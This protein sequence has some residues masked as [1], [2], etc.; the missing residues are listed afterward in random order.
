MI[1][2][3]RPVI[4]AWSLAMVGML[5]VVSCSSSEE[6]IPSSTTLLQPSSTDVES[7]TT[8]VD[9]DACRTDGATRGSGDDR[10]RCINGTWTP[11]PVSST[12]ASPRRNSP[13]IQ[14]FSIIS[15]L[16]NGDEDADEIRRTFAAFVEDL[17][18]ERADRVSGL[19]VNQSTLADYPV[20]GPYLVIEATSGWAGSQA[21]AE[22]TIELTFGLSQF[23]TEELLAASLDGEGMIN[24]ELIVDGTR[25]TITGT[26]MFDVQ[27]RVRSAVDVL[28]ASIR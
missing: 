14:N 6:A 2:S 18:L 12:T 3:I 5:V 20:A 23:W 1:H 7:T 25:Y 9:P 16:A 10:V 17:G 8:L 22:A 13:V 26:D 24:L 15:Q 27:R 28:E 11:D 21:Q 4:R 19:I